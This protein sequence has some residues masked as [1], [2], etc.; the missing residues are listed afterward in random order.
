M[1]RIWQFLLDPRVL[2]VIGLAALAGF[3]LVG[4]DA[5]RIGLVWAVLVL[6]LLLL[7]W[8]IVW[9]VRR[10]K[11]RK[12]A[13][14]LENAMDAEADKA[15]KAAAKAGKQDEV[16]AVRERMAEAVK[17]IKSSKLGE[18][19]GSAALYELPWY[20]V[21][22][23]PAAGKSS[24]VVKSGLKFP[25]ADSADN[26]I[27]GIGGTRH[28]DW[29]FTTEG[30]L[31]DTAG[32]YSVHEEDRKEWMGFLSLLK[33]HR[34]KA[35]LNGVIIAVSIAELG[36]NRP[37]FAI[38]L[39][40]K[41][42]QRV[43]ELT[44]KLEVFAPVYVVFTKADLIAGFVDFFEDRDRSERDKVWGA[45]LPY[46][47]T[48]TVDAVSQFE[49]HFDE[50]YQG[51][52]EASVARMSLH[53]GEQLPPGVLTF[54][55]EFAALKPAM[56]TFINT[57]FEENPYQ[58]RPIFRG[59][60]FTSAVQE[61]Q[62]TSRASERVAEQFGLQLQPG[63]SAAVY[64]NSGFF[65][66]EL[67]SRVIF[68][69]R[70]LVQQYTSRT[71]LR[72]RYATFFGGVLLLGALLA[73]WTW[74]YMGNRELVA[75]V[76]AD[77]VKAQQVQDNRV[78]LQSRLEALEIL[79][80]RLEQMQRYRQTRPWSIGLGLYQGQAIEDRLKEEYYN[81]LQVVMLK[82]TAQAIAA[83]LGDVNAHAADLRPL[84]FLPDPNAQPVAATPVA[85]AAP[86]VITEHANGDPVTEAPAAGSPY[87]NASS[88]N[89]TEAYNALKAYLML[90][91]R[92]RLEP[93]HMSD[94]LTRFWR[95]WL[96]ANRGNMPREQ[97]IQKAERIMSF[98]MAQMNDAA[99][100]E[101]DLNISLLDQ[102][103][104][105]LRRVIKGMPA[106]ERVY[107]EIKARAATRF[108]P[109][110]V[111]RL[112]SDA[113][114][115]V[116][117]G[118]YAVSGAFT[119]EA[120]NGYIK[121]AIKDAANS[122]LQSTDWVLKTASHDDL[123]LEGS[124]EQ[125]Q[126]SLTQLYKAEYVR[127]WQ[128]F[129]QSI[130][131]QDFGSFEVAVA[132]MNRLGDP[133]SSP[134]GTLLK[135]LYEQTSWDNPSLLDERLGQG[136]R[137]FMEWFKQRVLGAVPSPVTIN[138][139]INL[140]KE[141]NK[142]MGPIGKE[143]EA[144]GRLMVPR[145]DGAP[146]IKPYLESLSRI[147]SRFNQMKTQGDPG[148][149][150]RQLMLQ[151]LEGGGELGEALKMVDEQ[152]LNGMSDSA[153]AT[154]RPLLVRPLMQAF[155]VIVKPAE[156]ELNRVWMAQV[157][158]PYQRTLASKYPFDRSSRMEAA[159][160]EIAKVFGAEGVIAKF[161]EQSLGALVLKRG[162]GVTPRTWAD[163]GLRLRPEFVAGLGSW[164]APLN[165]QAAG[166]GGSSAAAGGGATAAADAQTVFQILPLAAPGL[167][168]YTVD[169][170]GQVMRY[171][172]GAASWT[173]FV[174]PGPGTPGVHITGMTLD[175]KPV[176]FFNESGRFG[177]E[178][179]INA[180]QRK[181][182]DNQLFELRW[183]Q[184]ANS[185]GV[186]LRIISNAATPA[187]AAPA[188][189]STGGNGPQAR[190][191]ALP[192]IIAGP[193]EAMANNNKQEGSAS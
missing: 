26:V 7:A 36:A 181:R 59:F 32:R 75:H 191:G 193:D 93:G 98:A 120:W 77:L 182:I 13:Q 133:T 33:R 51:L 62:S 136:K 91:D 3:L 15:M 172:N 97:L 123:T 4:A 50:L 6:G 11:A 102:T 21:I 130:S 121:D 1:Q 107:A 142:P 146:M 84:Q 122:E 125:I 139:E 46:D 175:G 73:A 135:T 60:Y 68:A 141:K 8:A 29:Y 149:A 114:R 143:F 27:Q 160:G 111:A 58:F 85:T 140:D 39:A 109:V 106:R 40:R 155:A 24:A 70:Q 76:Q 10:Y 89:V 129:M 52:K 137:T 90:G 16:A 20:A 34:P 100:P 165:G 192:S 169:I 103:R 163:M 74:S 65:L 101:Q 18:T 94:Q 64:S 153:R 66:K 150:S 71:K 88:T 132:N 151:T 134:V 54:P 104:D 171:R 164:I 31:L 117:A 47:T 166:G 144:V 19:S 127:E 152:M 186:Q 105:N 188:T 83:Y 138:A 38:D 161:V 131:V 170:D 157:F 162:D 180:A 53:R 63:T 49:T 43:Q 61:G 12:A 124:P 25:F 112:V 22:G 145:E 99:F 14:S 173:H 159:P 110:T 81:G 80:D 48:G 174:W 176:E 108:A 95:T 69:D 87:A 72:L 185:V 177:L 147:R 28:C 56:R 23:N 184:G 168:E 178:K 187:P 154:L 128:K 55:L 79:Q 189:A 116:V 41:L 118:G 2:A 44:E 158:E 67:F 17:L 42:R 37:E 45:T 30:I 86:G 113:D 179:M 148:P 96:D 190:P 82:P 115:Q 167:T 5:L 156:A 126:K 119:R 183:P 9:G 78:D 92:S 35:P 57:L